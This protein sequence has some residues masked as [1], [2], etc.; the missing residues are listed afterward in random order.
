MKKSKGRQVV[1]TGWGIWSSLGNSFEE[2]LK[3]LYYGQSGIKFCSEYAAAGLP[4][5]V[6]GELKDP[7]EAREFLGKHARK[8]GVG[9]LY[10]VEAFRQAAQ[11][12][13]LTE[14]EI[15]QAGVNV[16]TGGGAPL[17]AAKADKILRSR[18]V[19][20]IPPGANFQ[21]LPNNP[22]IVLGT[23]FQMTGGN[24]GI[25]SA[26]ATASNC[27]GD[28]FLRIKAGCNDVVFAGGCD[29]NDELIAATFCQLKALSTCYNDEPE[30]ASQP[31]DK[32]RDG[33]V[34]AG[35]AGVLVL[36]ELESALERKAPILAE[37]IGYGFSSDGF[38]F[39]APSGEGAA[40]CMETAL[41]SAGISPEEVDYINTHGTGTPAGDVAELQ[42]IHQVFGDP[43]KREFPLMV[44]STKA[45]SGHGLGAAG[46]Q[47]VIY[48][49][50]MMENGF[51]GP[52]NFK[53]L[54]P[55]AKEHG[56]DEGIL[57]R[58]RRYYP[59]DIFLSNSFGFG[60]SNASLVIRKYFPKE[61]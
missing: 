58:E 17:V 5:Q 32:N 27:I 35:G 7:Q 44:S 29:E 45:L 23:V 37:V 48:S 20:R 28:A 21:V 2:C 43:R 40:R 42:A 57:P 15:Q 33:F 9:T 6:R 38:N 61:K 19:K 24:Y 11:M 25:T 60:G 3:S 41:R 8:A 14:K 51:V 54:D 30:Q 49:L 55:E 1:I 4:S 50:I 10:A 36:E 39:T 18:G 31:Y 34:M 16:S 13:G 26:C 12:S 52:M 46:A 56:F 22:N 47:E 53:E 59:F